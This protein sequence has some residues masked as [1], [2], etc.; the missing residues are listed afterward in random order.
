LIVE[1]E[2]GREHR[3]EGLA[4]R[5]R[6]A[7]VEGPAGAVRVDG[8][9]KADIVAHAGQLGHPGRKIAE[10]PH[11]KPVV[12]SNATA[13]E[14]LWHRL[15]LGRKPWLWLCEPLVKRAMVE[16]ETAPHGSGVRPI[17]VAP[18]GRAQPRATGS[19]EMIHSNDPPLGVRIG[20]RR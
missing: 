16:G 8:A 3:H 10:E 5:Q 7:D 12:M 17:L 15:L 9:Q 6:L 14:E 18:L 4:R 1:E 20:S 19:I 13:H 2:L 11:D